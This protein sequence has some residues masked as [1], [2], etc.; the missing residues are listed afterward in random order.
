MNDMLKICEQMVLVDLLIKRSRDAKVRAALR[1]E[2][3]KLMVQLNDFL[4]AA[5]EPQK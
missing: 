3:K 2:Y 4:E 5:K 1:G